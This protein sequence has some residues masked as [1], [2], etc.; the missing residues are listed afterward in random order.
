MG[1]NHLLDTLTS[2]YYNDVASSLIAYL[3]GK[4]VANSWCTT[5]LED[6]GIPYKM[7]DPLCT[8]V[9]LVGLLSALDRMFYDDPNGVLGFFDFCFDINEKNTKFQVDDKMIA[10]MNRLSREESEDIKKTIVYLYQYMDYDAYVLGKF[11]PIIG[12]QDSLCD[13]YKILLERVSQSAKFILHHMKNLCQEEYVLLGQHFV[14]WYEK[15]YYTEDILNYKDW[16]NRNLSK[17]NVSVAEVMK[18]YVDDVIHTK[19]MYNLKSD[20]S[21]SLQEDNNV[22]NIESCMYEYDQDYNLYRLTPAHVR[23]D[24]I[25]WNMDEAFEMAMIEVYFIDANNQVNPNSLARFVVANISHYCKENVMK[26]LRVIYMYQLVVDDLNRVNSNNNKRSLCMGEDYMEVMNMLSSEKASLVW[27]RAKMYKLVKQSGKYYKWIGKGQDF[28][29]F[30][31]EAQKHFWSPSQKFYD[32]AP[33]EPFCDFFNVEFS[34]GYLR[35]AKSKLYGGKGNKYKVTLNM[36][37]IRNLY[38][39]IKP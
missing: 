28:A 33:W 6:C 19:M 14:S 12:M 37:N 17:K 38:Y 26:I 39:D 9:L 4:N 30:V 15:E 32:R 35:R 27:Q 22:L 10:K 1:N 20:L 7:K 8:C 11:P 18:S 3:K 2:S 21:F 36:K 23:K 16:K 31:Y 29:C 25:A 34:V 5:I 13:I 24:N